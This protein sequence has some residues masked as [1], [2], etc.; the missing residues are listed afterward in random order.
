M[1]SK[2]PLEAALLDFFN[3]ST[4]AQDVLPDLWDLQVGRVTAQ[5]AYRLGKSLEAKHLLTQRDEA[6]M[7]A[8]LQ[9]VEQKILAGTRRL[10]VSDEC[11]VQ[12]GWFETSL[13]RDARAISGLAQPLYQLRA[14]WERVQ[15]ALA[16]ERAMERCRS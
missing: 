13:T 8:L 9:V 10:F 14:A 5:A 3:C 6:D 4:H 12:G 1:D 2:D 15:N 16:V 7:H 11:C